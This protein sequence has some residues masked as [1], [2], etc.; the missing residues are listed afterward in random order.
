MNS[1]ARP[2]EQIV[3]RVAGPG[4]RAQLSVTPSSSE[5]RECQICSYAQEHPETKKTVFTNIS[6]VF[7]SE[8]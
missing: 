1:D 6:P 3:Y 8:D 5:M 7:F 4:P 2:R